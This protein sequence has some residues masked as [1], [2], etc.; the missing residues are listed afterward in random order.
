[1]E[2]EKYM[3]AKNI[4]DTNILSTIQDHHKKLKDNYSDRNLK[5]AEYE[6]IFLLQDDDLPSDDF[7]KKT[8]SPDP[9][10]AILGA[11]RLLT[12]AKPKWSV[13]KQVNTPDTL[14]SSTPIEKIAAAICWSSG[15][16]ARRPIWYD[17]TLSALLYS[18]VVIKTT[19]TKDLVDAA[20]T[21]GQKK[22]A[23]RAQRMTPIIIESLNP[24]NCFPEFDSMGLSAW[25]SSYTVAWGDII[26]MFGSIVTNKLAPEKKSYEKVTFNEFWDDTYHAVWLNEFVNEPLLFV[27]HNME[28]IPIVDQIIEGSEMFTEA[29]QQ[30]RQPFLYT[31]N[32]SGLWKRQNL[33]LTTLYTMIHAIGTN[34]MFVHTSP[35]ATTEPLKLDFSVPGG[36]VNLGVNEKLDALQK[37]VIDPSIIKGLDIAEQ[38]ST[39]STIYKQALGESLGANAPFSMVSMLSQA[40]RLPLIPYQRL[41]SFALADIMKISLDLLKSDGGEYKIISDKGVLDFYSKELPDA[42]ELDCDLDISMPTDERQNVVTASQATFGNNPLVSMEFA[43]ETWLGVESPD[44]MQE[45]IWAEQEA[46][47]QYQTRMQSQLQQQM[48]SASTG[49]TGTPG[50]QLG[51]LS[52]EAVNQLNGAQNTSTPQVGTPGLPMVNPIDANQGVSQGSSLPSQGQPPQGGNTPG[53]VG[54]A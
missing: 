34:P 15:R 54:G 9:R 43:R 30:T 11:Q 8:L 23:Q 49:G 10:N 38:K 16:I 45:Q 5:F 21:P 42:F 4:T 33:E 52:Q 12:A 19:A 26:S 20:T 22:R 18:E 31:V 48:Q 17:P 51:G 37:Q 35:T 27:E 29:G 36:V 39:E 44:E 53:S 50:K 6:K 32:E 46:T 3:T 13:P 14:K 47:A 7:V 24:K 28:V 41:V 40:G 1:V 2:N 25:G